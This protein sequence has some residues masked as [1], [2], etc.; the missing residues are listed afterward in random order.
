VPPKGSET[1]SKIS[2]EQSTA[3]KLIS[4]SLLPSSPALSED[5]VPVL[6]NNEGRK[7]ESLSRSNSLKD[8][9]KKGP[10]QHQV[11]KC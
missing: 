9:Q 11:Q 2:S 4:S 8:N 5:S 10:L 6:S 7:K 1:Y 3:E